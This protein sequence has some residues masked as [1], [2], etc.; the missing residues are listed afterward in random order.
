MTA[1]RRQ[2][3]LFGGKHRPPRSSVND[4]ALVESSGLFDAGYYLSRNDGLNDAEADPLAHYLETGAISRARPGPGFD[5]AW[6]L[7]TYPEIRSTGS[8]PLVYYLRTGRH[9]GHLPL[10]SYD[11]ALVR[12]VIAQQAV[13]DP[14]L[15]QSGMEARVETLPGQSSMAQGPL[16]RAWLTLL[17]SLDSSP[18]RLIVGEQTGYDAARLHQAVGPLNDPLFPSNLPWLFLDLRAGG[19][20]KRAAVR[21]VASSGR[22]IML[23]DVDSGSRIRLVNIVVRSLEIKEVVLLDAPLPRRIRKRYGKFWSHDTQV[24][25]IRG[26]W[27]PRAEMLLSWLKRIWARR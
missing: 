9:R 14:A 13:L 2:L 5:P 19:N 17:R 10:R 26:P 3:G 25:F 7:D 12:A 24:T 20:R 16:H 1:P 22:E 23:E 27:V 11:A 15:A 8:N 21:A 6:Y 18:D 4:R